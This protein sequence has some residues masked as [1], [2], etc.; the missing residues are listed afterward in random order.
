MKSVNPV[1]QTSSIGKKL[2]DVNNLDKLDKLDK[3]DSNET[4]GKKLKILVLHSNRQTSHLFKAKTEKFLEKKLKSIADLTYCNAPKLYEPAGKGKQLTTNI[5]NIS[6]SLKFVVIISGFYCRDTRPE[7]R[8]CLL[9]EVPTQHDPQSVKIRKDL[10]CIPSFH[11]WGVAD[12]LVS[13][14]RSEKLSDAFS[15]FSLF[16]GL[17]TKQIHIHPSGHFAK[18]IKFWPVQQMYEWLNIYC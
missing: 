18:A 9:E 8:S 13:P 7:F 6:K 12:E 10:I 15:S 11:S 17:Q 14:W 1:N 16:G 2:D 4:F 5:D 3:L